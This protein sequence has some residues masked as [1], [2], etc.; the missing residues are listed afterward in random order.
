MHNAQR[1]RALGTLCIVHCA[2][3]I[4]NFE[5][6][7][8]TLRFILTIV[9]AGVGAIVVAQGVEIFINR[10]LRP[11]AQEVTW[12]GDLV[13]GSGVMVMTTL[14]LQ[15]RQARQVSSALERER[16]VLDTQLSIAAQ[17]QRGLLPAV[18]ATIGGVSWSAMVEPA[19]KIGGDYYDF[20]PIDASSMCVVLADVSGKGIPAAVFLSN[21]RA[22]LRTLVR[23][24]TA[25]AEILARLSQAVLDDGAGNLYVTCL[26]A[27]VD[28]SGRTITY[29]NAGHP[30]GLLIG[31][32]GLRTLTAGGPPVGLLAGVTYEQESVGL[33]PGDLV[34]LVSDGV[35][36]A[37]DATGRE[38]PG[39]LA[40]EVSRADDLAPRAICE[41]LLRSARHGSGPGGIEGWADD[42]AV[43]VFSVGPRVVDAHVAPAP[44]SEV[45][46]GLQ[47]GPRRG[48][49]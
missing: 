10:M 48:V 20:L 5:S 18:P 44:A 12:I 38:G 39:T 6:V 27:V 28:T 23:E 29:A 16:L 24:T 34:V 26:V 42:R 33:A 3:C 45:G 25:P 21:V 41:R 7:M 35:T 15:L 2:L 30:A 11:D 47:T 4:V 31:R 19:G 13:A 1:I 46:A 9:L 49:A 22:V 14:W 43:V 37:L 32:Q 17:V 8:K 36:E 40:R